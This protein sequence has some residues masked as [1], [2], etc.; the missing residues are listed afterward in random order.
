MI[1]FEL[2]MYFNC[3][4]TKNNPKPWQMFI[5]VQFEMSLCRDFLTEDKA[6]EMK[7]ECSQSFLLMLF[8]FS[9]I[10]NNYLSQTES[11]CARIMLMF[12]CSVSG[13]MNVYTFYTKWDSTKSRCNE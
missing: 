12:T 6:M 2:K 8:Q 9:K 3:S 1:W 11:V 10:F 7:I 13:P 4:L 5:S